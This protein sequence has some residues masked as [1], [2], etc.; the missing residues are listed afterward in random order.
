MSVKVTEVS[1]LGD[2]SRGVVSLISDKD[3]FADQIEELSSA[4][5]R[6]EAIVAVAKK[7][8]KGQPGISRIVNP[9]HPVNA[10]GEVIENLKDS[11]G[12]PLP[13]QSPRMQ[14]QHYRITYELTI[15]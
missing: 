14:P 12:E 7:G 4:K 6:E 3:A 9:P 5:A 15:K 10:F 1:V 11:A 2:G 13:Q 8:V